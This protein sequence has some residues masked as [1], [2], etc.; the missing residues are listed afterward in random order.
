[1]AGVLILE[2]LFL[3]PYS[4]HLSKCR[5]S[6]LYEYLCKD[7]RN[8]VLTA[9]PINNLLPLSYSVSQH[10]ISDVDVL[11]LSVMLWI[12]CKYTSAIVVN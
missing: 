12:V 6:F 2:S 3:N 11:C 10:M 8:V 1:M 5:E 4:Y 9:N 7:V